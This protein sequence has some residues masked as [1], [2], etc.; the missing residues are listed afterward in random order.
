ML[1]TVNVVVVETSEDD[2]PEIVKVEVPEFASA[3]TRETNQYVAVPPPDEILHVVPDV[4]LASVDVTIL[5]V[6]FVFVL[7]PDSLKL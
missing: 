7:H 5:S 4:P 1:L 2:G 6:Q 3:L